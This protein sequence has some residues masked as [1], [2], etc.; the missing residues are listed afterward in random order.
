L[1]ENQ[2]QIVFLSDLLGE[3]LQPYSQSCLASKRNWQDGAHFTASMMR[4]EFCPTRHRSFRG[5]MSGKSSPKSLARFKPSNGGWIGSGNEGHVK[6]KASPVQE[7]PI[8]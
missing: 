8:T 4:E 2:I 7:Q 6:K 5:W 1:V 3:S